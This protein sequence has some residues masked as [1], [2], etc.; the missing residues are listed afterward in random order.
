MAHARFR[1]DDYC[2]LNQIH[3]TSMESVREK[4]LI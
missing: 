3:A 2:A 4:S 1:L